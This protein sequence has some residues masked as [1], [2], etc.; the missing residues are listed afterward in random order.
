MPTGSTRPLRVVLALFD[1]R[2][3]HRGDFRDGT[4]QPQRRVDAV[5]EQ[6]ARDA[7]AGDRHIEAPQTFASLR[8]VLEIV[9]SCRNFAR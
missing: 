9:Q 5:R 1:E 4:V 6:I 2:L 8:Q 7:A 3:G